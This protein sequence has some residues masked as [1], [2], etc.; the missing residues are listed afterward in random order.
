M[1]LVLNHH[2]KSIHSMQMLSYTYIEAYYSLKDNDQHGLPA[3]LE[4]LSFLN[5]S[6]EG[7]THALQAFLGARLSQPIKFYGGTSKYVELLV[8]RT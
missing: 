3:E 5:E 4:Y 2:R 6:L 1:G 7:Q 8:F